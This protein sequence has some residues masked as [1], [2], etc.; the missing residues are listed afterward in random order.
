MTRSGAAAATCALRKGG[1][2][3]THNRRCKQKC[4]SSNSHDGLLLAKRLVAAGKLQSQQS[5][6]QCVCLVRPRVSGIFSAGTAIARRMRIGSYGLLQPAK[7]SSVCKI[8]ARVILG[9]ARYPQA[10][11]Y[12]RVATADHRGA[13]I[14]ERKRSAKSPANLSSRHAHCAEREAPS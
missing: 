9:W 13:R 7:F 2:R 11:L 12:N 3:R 6:A 14:G 5:G 4:P 1:A 10:L 8:A